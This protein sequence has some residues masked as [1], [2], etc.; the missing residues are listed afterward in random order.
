MLLQTIS[1]GYSISWYGCLFMGWNLYWSYGFPPD[2]IFDVGCFGFIL[3]FAT[4][5]STTNGK[6]CL[7]DGFY[8]LFV[9]AGSGTNW[10]GTK[11]SVEI[12]EMN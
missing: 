10:I 1:I 4:N 3:Y 6:P 12:R 2:A 9:P 8:R 5:I 7:V 11:D